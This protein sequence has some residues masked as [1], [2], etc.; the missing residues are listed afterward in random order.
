MTL[1]LG[2]FRPDCL[3]I[4]IDRYLTATCRELRSLGVAL[5]YFTET[6]PLPVNADI[7]WDPGTGRPAPHD[8]L[9][10][11]SRPL[12]VTYHGAANVSMSLGE[13]F[14]W[15]LSDVVTGMQSRI[16]T[17][18][19]WRAF[20]GRR[21]R[22]IAVSD[23]AAAELLRFA[24]IE[25][26][27]VAIIGHG[28]DHEIFRPDGPA[29]SDP[30]PFFLHVSSNQPKKNVDRILSAF[31]RLDPETSPRLMVVAPGYPGQDIPPN[32]ELIGTA[33]DHAELAGLYRAAVGFIFPSLHETFGMPI[34]EA[35]ASGCPVLTSFDTGCA[36]TAGDAAL[37]VNPRSVDQIAS[38]MRQISTDA[39]LRDTLRRKGLERAKAF[40]WQTCARQHLE[41][42]ERSVAEAAAA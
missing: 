22:A 13:C 4:S 12:V 11:A 7:H 1:C 23:F 37:L 34:L 19:G 27:D 18:R 28:V 32:V 42:F 8:R 26:G 35:M 2:V 31:A 25:P 14:S 33:L 29:A 36:E 24:P 40:D 15:G 16:R 38:A 20:E 10:T 41:F 39:G 9:Q 3:P 21:L 17:L 30:A 5:E 6:D